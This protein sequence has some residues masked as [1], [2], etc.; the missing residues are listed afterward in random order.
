[1]SAGINYFTVQFRTLERSAIE[2]SPTNRSI[3][4]ANSGVRVL[5]SDLAVPEGM[6]TLS[7][8]W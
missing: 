3:T 4:P 1:M 6:G 2:A 7:R 5:F 8:F